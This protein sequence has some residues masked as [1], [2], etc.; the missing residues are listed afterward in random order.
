MA[1]NAGRDHGAP[2]MESPRPGALRHQIRVAICNGG[3][4]AVLRFLGEP[5]LNEHSDP[6]PPLGLVDVVWKDPAFFFP[7]V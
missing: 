2:L 7:V 1:R 6:N 4:V 3:P 5:K